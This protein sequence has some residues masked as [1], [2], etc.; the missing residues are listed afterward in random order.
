[1]KTLG[2][3][4]WVTRE[5]GHP[6]LTKTAFSLKIGEVSRPVHTN[7]GYHIIRVVDIRPQEVIP[8][9]DDTRYK[10]R[11]RWNADRVQAYAERLAQRYKVERYP[12]VYELHPKAPAAAAEQA[13]V[14]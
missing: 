10:I 5:Q 11:A 12:E 4:G 9:D 3:I 14:R 8:L 2:M 6:L 7:A 13:E 1:E